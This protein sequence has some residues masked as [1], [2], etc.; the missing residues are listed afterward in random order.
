MSETQFHLRR[1][2]TEAGM[3]FDGLIKIGVGHLFD[4]FGRLFD[5]IVLFDIDEFCGFP[6]LLAVLRHVSILLW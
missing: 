1:I 4:E 2:D 6:I 5:R 3:D